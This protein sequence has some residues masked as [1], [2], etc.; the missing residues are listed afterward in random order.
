MDNEPDYIKELREI[1]KSN[2]E[3]IRTPARIMSV[4]R[5][6]GVITIDKK[7]ADNWFKTPAGIAGKALTVELE[8]RHFNYW[9]YNKK[10]H[11]KQ[12]ISFVREFIDWLQKKLDEDM[13]AN[14]QLRDIMPTLSKLYK[15]PGELDHPYAKK[16]AE[17]KHS[18]RY[19]LFWYNLYLKL[20]K[21]WE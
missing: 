3:D 8:I 19:R 1:Y 4:D 5:K 9:M 15:F 21:I 6:T 18:F 13:I 17:I 16:I 12:K 10:L 11:R 14:K 2:K 20:K 7:A